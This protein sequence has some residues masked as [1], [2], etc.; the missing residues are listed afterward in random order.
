M[1]RVLKHD[2]KTRNN[3]KNGR[4]GGWRDGS[5]VKYISCP[6]KG[7]MFSSQNSPKELTTSEC[8]DLTPRA[9]HSRERINSLKMSSD[10]HLPSYGDIYASTPTNVQK[11]TWRDNS[12]TS[13][14]RLKIRLHIKQK[15]F[16]KRKVVH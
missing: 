10:F 14:M 16:L 15:I 11:K 9:H 1:L 7:S 4:K 12:V 8:H 3:L 2:L 6:S 5:V 13:P